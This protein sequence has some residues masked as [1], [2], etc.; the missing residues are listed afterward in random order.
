MKLFILITAVLALLLAL[1]A[2]ESLTIRTIIPTT[3]YSQNQAQENQTNVSDQNVTYYSPKKPSI[4]DCYDT[5]YG[6]NILIRGTC[7]D[8]ITHEEGTAD[9]CI[10][11]HRL[12]EFYCSNDLKKGCLSDEI[13]CNTT[14]EEG[15][16]ITEPAQNP[17]Q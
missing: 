6:R 5:D 1:T 2:C 9:Y 7:Y 16:C 3:F 11:I 10:D 4:Y 14:C 17:L 13:Y 8:H 15:V 12:V